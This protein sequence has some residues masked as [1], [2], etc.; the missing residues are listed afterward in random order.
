MCSDVTLPADS[1]SCCTFSCIGLIK[2]VILFIYAC[3]SNTLSVLCCCWVF[4]NVTCCCSFFISTAL[5]NFFAKGTSSSDFS[6]GLLINWVHTTFQIHWIYYWF[7]F[8]FM[9]PLNIFYIPRNIKFVIARSS[10][11]PLWLVWKTP[12]S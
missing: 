10:W 9:F 4:N 1:T 11:L 2:L 7:L 5:A 8:F 6:F 12:C 3:N